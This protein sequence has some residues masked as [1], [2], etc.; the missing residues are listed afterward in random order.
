MLVLDLEQ[1]AEFQ[2]AAAR[3]RLHAL[4]ITATDSGARPGE[5][6]ALLWSDVDFER[7]FISIMK[8]LE[9]INGALRV[10]DVKT[11]KSRRRVDLSRHTLAILS[12]HRKRM[13]AE[14]H[15]APDRAVFCDTDGGYLRLSNLHKNSFKPILANA[16]LP[17]IRLYDLRHTCATLLL[18]AD[19]PAKVVSERLGHSSITLTLD[20][21]SHVLP[22]M[23]Q[24]AADVMG[25]LLG[26]KP[27]TKK[28]N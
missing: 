18:L 6:F 20:T 26:R 4:Y 22:T 14:G 13:L 17:A 25:R 1:L 7:G 23:Q 27:E 21:Y 2:K 3:D 15:Y 8:S 28:A 24:R 12:E 16:G 19:V 9:E 11:P 5:L 10:K